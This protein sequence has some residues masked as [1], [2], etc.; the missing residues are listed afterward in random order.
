MWTRATGA[1][2]SD[3]TYS[4]GSNPAAFAWSA[5]NCRRA[6]KRTASSATTNILARGDL[7]C[8]DTVKLLVGCSM[9][10]GFKD[11]SLLISSA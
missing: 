3:P 10:E 6:V 8:R 1:S 4:A 7:P 5:E 11:G 9:S 2:D